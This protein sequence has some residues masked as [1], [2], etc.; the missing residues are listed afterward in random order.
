MVENC[1]EKNWWLFEKWRK[2][3]V[4]K[5]FLN[6]INS[7]VGSLC[8]LCSII[9]NDWRIFFPTLESVRALVMRLSYSLWL[10]CELI[11][12]I[13]AL[14][15]EHTNNQNWRIRI[16]YFFKCEEKSFHFSSEKP[17]NFFAWMIYHHWIGI[18][19][20]KTLRRMRIWYE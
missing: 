6:E 15:I 5:K 10:K 16:Y 12:S 20:C 13:W 9:M 19:E 11:Q 18:S 7:E 14:S 17:F 8:V 1:H 4:F 3:V 2:N